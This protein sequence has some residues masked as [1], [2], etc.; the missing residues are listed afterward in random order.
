MAKTDK[1]FVQVVKALADKESDQAILDIINFDKIRMERATEFVDGVTLKG[2]QL[3]FQDEPIA[4]VLGER[5]VQML[6]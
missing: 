3:Y 6:D 5:M 1:V 2:S 4:G